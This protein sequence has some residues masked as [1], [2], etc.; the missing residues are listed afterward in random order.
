MR[1]RVLETE[2]GTVLIFDR[3]TLE[4]CRTIPA[5]GSGWMDRDDRPFVLGASGEIE[6]P[7]VDRMSATDLMDMQTRV[8]AMLGGL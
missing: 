5:L 6:I 7:E 2:A 8:N 1:L 3:L 4:E